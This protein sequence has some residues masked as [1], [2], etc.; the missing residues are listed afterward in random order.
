M[1]CT[2]IVGYRYFDFVDRE[3]KVVT[4]KVTISF[5][6]PDA[7]ADAGEMYL[8]YSFKAENVPKLTPERCAAPF[9]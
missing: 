5:K 7:I 1:L 4:K 2:Q 8:T 9:Y 3:S 6:D